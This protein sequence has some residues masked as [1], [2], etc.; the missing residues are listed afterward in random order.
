[1]KHLSSKNAKPLKIL[2]KYK[3]Y[4]SNYC[5]EGHIGPLCERCDLY[6]EFWGD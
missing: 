2:Q 5:S 4:P 1:M 3:I 6:G